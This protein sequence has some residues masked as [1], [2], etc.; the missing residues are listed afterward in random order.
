M[1]SFISSSSNKHLKTKFLS[2]K[3]LLILLNSIFGN[4]AWDQK[5]LLKKHHTHIKAKKMQRIWSVLLLIVQN[6][7]K[8]IK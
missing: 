8:Q 5:K 1:K 3:S 6:A 7:Y 2:R 4:I